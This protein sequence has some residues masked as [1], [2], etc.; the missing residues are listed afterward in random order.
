MMKRLRKSKS[1]VYSDEDYD[2]EDYYD[3]YYEGEDEEEETS[4]NLIVKPVDKCLVE[5]SLI[6]KPIGLRPLDKIK[7]V[8][9]W[10]ECKKL[11]EDTDQ[12]SNWSWKGEN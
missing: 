8:Q 5:N 12:C 6:S 3:E 10:A 9:S 7:N 1:F 11:C 4:Q 2:D